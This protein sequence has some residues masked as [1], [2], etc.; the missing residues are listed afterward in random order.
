MSCRDFERW[1]VSD[2]PAERA[3]LERHALACAECAARLE[4]HDA[5]RAAARR[6]AEAAPDPRA[7]LAAR[8]HRAVACEAAIARGREPRAV[9]AARPAR[10]ARPRWQRWASGAAG[11]AAALIAAAALVVYAPAPRAGL[12]NNWDLERSVS[13][14]ERQ[15]RD[16]AELE[17]A[18]RPVLGSAAQLPPE[19][20]SRLLNQLDRIVVL[21]A[22]IAESRAYLQE[23]PRHAGARRLLNEALEKKARLLREVLSTADD[24]PRPLAN[25]SPRGDA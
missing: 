10:T 18:A 24:T 8:V 20:A 6:W 25:E 4:R 22:R 17:R 12:L 16:L 19:R 7:D 2:A 21:D 9:R 15:A 1:V 14:E 3:A 13:S 5:L 11:I 23:N